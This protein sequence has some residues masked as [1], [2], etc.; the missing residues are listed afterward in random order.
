MGISTKTVQLEAMQFEVISTIMGVSISDSFDA[1]SSDDNLGS[2]LEDGTLII[3]ESISH[4]PSEIF[5]IV[6]VDMTKLYSNEVSD[7]TDLVIRMTFI[8]ESLMWKQ[9]N[10]LNKKQ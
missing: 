3:S 2:L 10:K 8:S 5:T 4:E 6:R 9:V 1:I 7:F